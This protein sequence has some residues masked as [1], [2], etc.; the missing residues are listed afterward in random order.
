MTAST[1]SDGLARTYWASAWA[2]ASVPCPVMFI[3]QLPAIKNF[4]FGASCST[5]M[6]IFHSCLKLLYL[7]GTK[8]DALWACNE[9]S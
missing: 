8:A 3:F 6:F 4:G 1:V 5:M 9:L 7:Y 2:S